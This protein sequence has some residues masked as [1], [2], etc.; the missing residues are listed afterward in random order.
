MGCGAILAELSLWFG[1][2]LIE[3]ELGSRV[4]WMNGR[5]TPWPDQDLYRYIYMYIDLGSDQ[6]RFMEEI[7]RRKEGKGRKGRNNERVKDG[8]K[9]RI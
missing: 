5:K 2:F 9:V 8:K 3:L 6:R 7:T 1:S 4:G